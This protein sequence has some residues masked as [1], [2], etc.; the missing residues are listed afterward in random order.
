[1]PHGP[2]TYFPKSVSDF[3]ICFVSTSTA[4]LFLTLKFKWLILFTKAWAF[5]P[6]VAPVTA[7]VGGCMSFIL[8]NC[9]FSYDR[10]GARTMASIYE[11]Y[12]RPDSIP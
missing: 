3:I 10:R 7:T 5:V 1:V 4:I 6:T 9:L 2:H 11:I 8:L 12:E